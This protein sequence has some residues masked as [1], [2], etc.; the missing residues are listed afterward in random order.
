MHENID[1]FNSSIPK[2]GV[3][4]YSRKDFNY[5]INLGL[6]DYHIEKGFRR[7]IDPSPD[8]VTV[9]DA[10]NI[11]KYNLGCANFTMSIHRGW[12]N[13]E[14]F[15]NRPGQNKFLRQMKIL[16]EEKSVFLNADLEFGIPAK[17]NSLDVVYHCLLIDCFEYEKALFFLECIYHVLRAGGKHRISVI[18][19]SRLVEAYLNRDL[20]ISN[21]EELIFEK[22][23]AHRRSNLY[24]ASASHFS[25][26]L[27]NTETRSFWDFESLS[28]SL[29][30]VGFKNI[31]LSALKQTADQDIYDVESQ[32]HPLRE[33]FC[34]FVDCEK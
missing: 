18:D 24:K 33:K 16:S 9:C 13:I 10:M 21:V 23:F 20:D 17:Q 31:K 34:L 25:G 4:S 3:E 12:L 30:L 15:P 11:T 1:Q 28:D 22:K 29:A 5:Y 6:S 32:Y 26:I 19:G 14:L 7:P 2:F 8:L 27:F